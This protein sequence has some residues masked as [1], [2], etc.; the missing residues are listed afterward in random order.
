VRA[1]RHAWW[2]WRRR[3]AVVVAGS[4]DDSLAYAEPE[5]RGVLAAFASGRLLHGGEATRAAVRALM[6]RARV[7]HF[8]CHADIPT[9]RPHRARVELPSG[10]QWYASEWA[11]EPV[12]DL[13]LVTLS[14]CRAG[15]VASLFGREVFGLVTG[16]LSG[17][18]RAVVAGLWSVPDRQAMTFMFAFYHHLMAHDPPAALA[19]AQREALDDARSNPLFWSV[20][21]VFGDPRTLPPPFAGIRWWARR[22]QARY[23]QRCRAIQQELHEAQARGLGMM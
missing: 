23:L 17:G 7:V 15:E 19:K 16:V 13:P 18:A 5:G 22:R 10:E 9:G 4:P 1:R 2:R 3:Q 12:R 21:A 20:F 8:A 14:A 11:R 6:P